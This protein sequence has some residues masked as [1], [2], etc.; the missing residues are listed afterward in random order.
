M[1][2]TKTPVSLSFTEFCAGE[3]TNSW[4]QELI[5]EVLDIIVKDER[6]DRAPQDLVAGGIIMS[7]PF[8]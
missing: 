8:I 7:A 3:Q 2:I 6:Q 4:W 5:S 1:C